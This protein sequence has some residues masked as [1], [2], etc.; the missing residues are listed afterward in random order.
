MHQHT[1]T[2]HKMAHHA[3]SPPARMVQDYM[4]PVSHTLDSEDTIA[5]AGLLMDLHQLREIVVLQGGKLMQVISRRDIT[6]LQSFRDIDTTELTLEEVVM[7]TPYTLP[8]G[9]SLDELVWAMANGKRELAVIVRGDE[10]LG[11]FTSADACR[12][13]SVSLGTEPAL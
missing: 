6:L 1:D 3:L 8:P 13:L 10:V 4:T 11:L 9:A 12:F 5:R 2:R 7:G